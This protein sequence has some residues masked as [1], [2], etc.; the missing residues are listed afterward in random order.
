MFLKSIS[1]TNFKGFD[2]L[3]FNFLGETGK[4]R[5][6][7]LILGQN[8]T[9]K[10][11]VLKAIALIT[12]GSEA[13]V[14]LLLNPDDWV[15]QGKNEAFISAILVTQKNEERLVSLTIER[16][17]NR[18]SLLNRNHEALSELDSALIHT[19]RSYF[20]AGYGA[21]RRHNPNAE[22]NSS[23]ER[24]NISERVSNIYTLFNSDAQL[25]S[26]TSWAMNLDYTSGG[27]KMSVI[28]TTLNYFLEGFKFHSIDKKNRTLLFSEGKNLL[29]LESLSD[30]YQNMA[31]WIGDLLYRLTE[32]FNDYKS[33]LKVRGILLIDEIDLHLHPKWQRKLLDFISTKLPNMQVI[34]TTHSPLLAQQAK[35]GELYALKKGKTKIEL[36]AFVGNPEHLLVHQMLMSPVFGLETDESFSVQKQKEL[37]KS[38]KEG[39]KSPE[40]EIELKKVSDNLNSITTQRTNSLLSEEDKNLL[41]DIKEAILKK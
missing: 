24:F 29:K 18:N 35:E 26:L 15:K 12:S 28:K 14:D 27:T 3:T 6:Q 25:N 17:G 33:P 40:N 1:L 39:T 2:D 32:T 38:I 23:K 10:S 22:F 41:K 4:I 30:G 31:A 7:T 11:N 9:G 19:K 16:G 8:G 34:A 37:Y 20:V 36:I 5:K 13:I 21:S